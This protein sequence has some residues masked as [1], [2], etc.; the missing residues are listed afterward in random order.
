MKVYRH[1]INGHLY[2]LYE[3]VRLGC[4]L[5]AIPYWG[6][7]PLLKWVKYPS[8]DFHYNDENDFELVFQR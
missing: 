6:I 5:E 8:K 1:K 4:S 2:Y 7:S 3:N